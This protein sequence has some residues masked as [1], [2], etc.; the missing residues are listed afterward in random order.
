MT[1]LTLYEELAREMDSQQRLVK[2]LRENNLV[3]QSVLL[4]SE[5]GERSTIDEACLRYAEKQNWPALNQV[6]AVL[7]Y[8]RVGHAAQFAEFLAGRGAG[9]FANH[10][11]DSPKPTVLEFLLIDYW[12]FAGNSRWHTT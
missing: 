12:H 1:W 10:V 5:P 4:E 6:Q 8:V 3:P 11:L 7:A 9:V 2:A